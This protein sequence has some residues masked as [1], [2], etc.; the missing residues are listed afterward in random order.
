M[1]LA[2]PHLAV[3]TVSAI[4]DGQD[5]IVIPASGHHALFL[6]KMDS[7]FIQG[8]EPVL[9]F[10]AVITDGLEIAAASK[11]IVSSLLNFSF[12]IIIV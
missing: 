12:E 8:L 7:A 4:V 9:D 10:A 5:L 3:S 6:V 1:V 11:L 2:E